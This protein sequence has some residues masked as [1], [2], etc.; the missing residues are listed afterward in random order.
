ME[1]GVRYIMS[2]IIGRSHHHLGEI[3]LI[4]RVT[5]FAASFPEFPM[6]IYYITNS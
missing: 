6:S 3:L 1:Y 5:I 2:D 4:G